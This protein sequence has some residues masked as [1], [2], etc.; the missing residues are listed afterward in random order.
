MELDVQPIFS[1]SSRH[2]NRSL[3]IVKD[4]WTVQHW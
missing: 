4:N 2:K 1:H 3:K